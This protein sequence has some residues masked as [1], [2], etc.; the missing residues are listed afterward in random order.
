MSR[1]ERWY[2]C[3]CSCPKAEKKPYGDK[4]LGITYR[5]MLSNYS[6]VGAFSCEYTPKEKSTI[7][8][9]IKNNQGLEYCFKCNTKTVKISTGMFTMY[10]IC[11]K[12]KI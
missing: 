1:G 8:N 11:P 9:T 12:C 7:R 6:I 5:Y 4:E 3:K 10:D 2:D